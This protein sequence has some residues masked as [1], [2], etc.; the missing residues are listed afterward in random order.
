MTRATALMVTALL[1]VNG[2]AT[3]VPTVDYRGLADLVP[4]KAGGTDAGVPYQLTDSRLVIGLVPTGNDKELL[5]P[6]SLDPVTANANPE[7]LKYVARNHDGKAGVYAA[8][9]VEGMVRAGDE[10]RL[11]E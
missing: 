4:G 6:I 1:T 8:V 5:P 2:C 3:P 9:L 7:I 10:I 11:V